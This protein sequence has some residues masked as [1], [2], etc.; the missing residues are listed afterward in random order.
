ME[1]RPHDGLIRL[2]A[3][4]FDVLNRRQAFVV[5]ALGLTS[6]IIARLNFDQAAHEIVLHLWS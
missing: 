6:P 4:L 2:L 1:N 3:P 5:P